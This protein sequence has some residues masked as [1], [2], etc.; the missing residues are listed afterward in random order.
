MAKGT[1]DGLLNWGAWPKG[2]NSIS[3]AGDNDYMMKLGDKP[4]MMA[5]SPWFYTNLPTYSKNWLWRGDSLWH[6]RWNQVFEL[7]PA[8]VRSI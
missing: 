1:A 3:T 8:M 2:P 7:Q 6:D 5:V 4:Y